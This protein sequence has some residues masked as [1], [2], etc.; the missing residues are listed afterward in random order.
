MKFNKGGKEINL[1][2]ITNPKE[3]LISNNSSTM[4][5]RSQKGVIVHVIPYNFFK[6]KKENI[7]LLN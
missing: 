3:N 5:S 4:C 2:G 1:Q 7:V 6:G